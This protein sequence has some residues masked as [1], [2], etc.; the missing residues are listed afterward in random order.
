MP[1]KE[2]DDWPLRVQPVITLARFV[3][4]LLLNRVAR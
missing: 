3:H 4:H 1:N 2:K